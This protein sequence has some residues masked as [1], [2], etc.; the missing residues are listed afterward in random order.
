MTW[1][2]SQNDITWDQNCWTFDGNNGCDDGSVP[3]Q[4]GTLNFP[5]GPGFFILFHN[6]P[7]KSGGA[8]GNVPR[9]TVETDINRIRDD[10]EELLLIIKLAV[11]YRLI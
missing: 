3:S 7:S 10:D 11:A 2:W 8:S 4:G 5:M 9:G 1:D 6:K